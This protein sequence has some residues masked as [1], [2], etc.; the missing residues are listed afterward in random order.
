MLVERML[1]IARKRLATMVE[2]A[3]VIEAARLLHRGTDIV[4]VCD[5]IGRLSGVI[6]KGDVVSQISHCC[7]ASCTTGAIAV[8]TREVATCHPRDALDD[9]WALMRDRVL[10]NIPVIDDEHYP[11]GV[12]SANDALQELLKEVEDEDT[13]LK[14]Y[15][16]GIGYR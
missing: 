10:K 16:M 7:G 11:L 12:L 3:P 13:L 9:V 5:P 15:V 14:D 1:P 2:S 6:T 4:V 8:M